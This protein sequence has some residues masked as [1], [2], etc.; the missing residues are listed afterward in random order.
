[1][2]PYLGRGE[3]GAERGTKL[4]LIGMFKAISYKSFLIALQRV[5]RK[6]YM[7]QKCWQAICCTASM[8][9]IP[10]VSIIF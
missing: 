9:S 8:F 2:L 1:M 7:T 5:S 3:A 10:S 6:V 4:A